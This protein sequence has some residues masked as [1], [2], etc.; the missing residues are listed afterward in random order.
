MHAEISSF[1]FQIHFAGLIIVK[2][3]ILACFSAIFR[4]V[5][6]QGDRRNRLKSMTMGDSR[7]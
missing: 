6:K 1:S 7:I 2:P 3:G 5:G 4:P